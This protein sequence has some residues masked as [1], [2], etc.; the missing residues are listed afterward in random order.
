MLVK[1]K[2][3]EIELESK[4]DSLPV[5]GN[6]IEESLKHFKADP[7]TLY[8]IQLA[9]DEASTNVINYAYPGS[10]G[11][12]KITLELAGEDILVNIRD[13]GKSF[14]PTAVPPPDISSALDDRKIGGLGIYFMNKL[15]DSVSYSFDPREGNCLTLRKTISRNAS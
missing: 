1:A 5:I 8:K 4:I 14:D 9:V 2:V 10:T 13:K 6:F 15:M 7:S 12:L 11:P 3:F